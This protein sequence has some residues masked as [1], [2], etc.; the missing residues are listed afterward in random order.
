LS[1][2]VGMVHMAR[3]GL[4]FAI[5]AIR[6]TKAGGNYSNVGERFYFPEGDEPEVQTAVSPECERG[7]CAHCTG[8]FHLPEQTEEPI[9]CMHEC[10]REPHEA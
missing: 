8:I 5:L 2:N 1:R 9:F 10:H 3:A 4:R 6:S 7:D